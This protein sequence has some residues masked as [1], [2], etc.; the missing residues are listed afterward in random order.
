VHAC[1]IHRLIVAV[2]IATATVAPAIARPT[3][4][5]TTAPTPTPVADPTVTKIA[6]QQFV[7]WQAG[8]INKSLYAPAVV[9]K[10]TDA[11]INDVARVLAALGPLTDTAFIGPFSA[12]D[13]PPEAHGF[14]YQM[15]CSG[16]NIY[17]WMILDANGKIATIFFKDKLDVETIERP[18]TPAPSP[19]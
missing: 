7:A 6:R 13:I 1:R 15:R 11:K 16:G 17:L 19:P 12:A 2:A 10:L 5:P 18:G 3:A 4:T 14:I 8:S 9:P